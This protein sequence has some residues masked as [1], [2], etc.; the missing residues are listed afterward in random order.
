[1]AMAQ[2]TPTKLGRYEIVDE[3]GKGAMGVV[4]LAKDPLIG[5]LVALKTFRVG[6]SVK[7]EELQ[8]FRSRFIREAQSAGILSHP[9]IV[10]IHDVVDSSDEGATFIAMEYVRGT[11]LK[12]LLQSEHGISVSFAIDVVSQVAS[13]LDYAHSKGVVHR[14]IKPANILITPDNRVKLTDFGIA[15]MNT[16]NLTHEGQLLGTPN[17]MAPEQILGKELDHRAD[18]FSL[19][20]VFYEMLTR[21]KPFQGENLTVVTH[22]IVY[23]AFTPPEQHVEGITPALRTVL[24]RALE[25]DPSRRYQHAGEM[26]DELKRIVPPSGDDTSATQDVAEFVPPPPPPPPA[27]WKRWLD[28]AG[29]RSFAVVPGSARRAQARWVVMAMAGLAL[30][31]VATLGVM[32]ARESAA[33]TADAVVAAPPTGTPSATS[34]DLGRVRYDGLLKQAR[35]ALDAGDSAQAIRLLSNAQG[36]VSDPS[37]ARAALAV[38]QQLS[39]QQGERAGQITA[40][41]SSARTAMDQK[42]YED[43][44]SA[45]QG[46]LAISP[47]EAEAKSVIVDAEAAIAKRRST[48]AK[49]AV[50]APP[51]PVPAPVPT[52]AESA[53]STGPSTTTPVGEAVLIVDFYSDASEG[54][55]T[56]YAGE[57]Q[58]LREPFHFF[59][60]AGVFKTEPMSG[61]I[62]ARRRVSAG[63]SNIRIYLTLGDRP[64]QVTTLEGNFLGG[65]ERVLQIRVSK[66]GQVSAA[67]N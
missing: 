27:A 35:Q 7:D 11:N 54:V 2:G 24:H 58:V 51:P 50:P 28:G 41:L 21:R 42:R 63:P 48:A 33:E 32:F 53:A 4:Y 5:R 6:Y 26:A 66:D 43:A 3:I 57:R 12:E 46:V 38:A 17:Y 22:R 31:L 49:P 39:A 20:V 45:A 9:N 36:L 37:E 67:L 62:E 60:K 19:G 14:D 34:P 65:S 25:K 52:P 23:D 56:I 47:E 40:G 30:L 16:S 1:M 59:K 55:L 10:T 18:V 61:K 44:R 15:R 64:A 29:S 13:A 8:Q